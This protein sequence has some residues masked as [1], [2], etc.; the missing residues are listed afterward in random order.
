MLFLVWAEPSAHADR[1]PRLSKTLAKSKHVKERVAA[2]VSLGRL[3]DKRALRPLARALRDRSRVV[4]SVAATALGYLGESGA[5]PALRKATEDADQGVR[6]R[7]VSAIARINTKTRK[8]IRAAS[9]AGLGLS[10]RRRE[11]ARYSI[12][13]RESPRQTPARPGFFVDLKSS[14]DKSQ[15]RAKRS[16]RKRRAS[17]VRA[18]VLSELSKT[19]KIT[20][21]RL[22][23]KRLALTSFAVDVSILRLKRRIRGKFVEIDCEIQVAI[24][25]QRGKMVSFLTGGAKVQVPRHSFRSEY[26]RLHQAEAL[27]NAARSVSQDL[28]VYLRKLHQS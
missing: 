13:G 10:K 12:S 28:I 19:E 22:T 15:T 26:E 5:L 25:N 2:A 6:L 27:E 7:A 20:T 18:L 14:I 9:R 4:R 23:A 11:L 24:S 3:R 16:L 17:K 8:P 1:I 21:N